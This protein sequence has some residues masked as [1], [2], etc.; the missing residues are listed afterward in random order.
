MSQENVEIARQMIAC[1]NR[2]DDAGVA[3]LMSPDVKCFPAANQPEPQPFRG[4][5]AFLRYAGEWTDAF[6][7][8]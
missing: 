7:Y 8:C 2:G 6:D 1:V 5:E 3:D 4:R